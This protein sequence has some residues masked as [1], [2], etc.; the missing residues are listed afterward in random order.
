MNIKSTLWYV[1]A[2]TAAIAALCVEQ[3]ISD[4]Q[5][6]NTLY[7][8][9]LLMLYLTALLLFRLSAVFNEKLLAWL[10]RYSKL[11]TAA[12]LLLTLWEALSTKSDI[13]KLPFFP[14]PAQIV[15]TLVTERSTLFVSTLYSL[16]LFFAGLICGVALGITT[17]ILIGWS[18][19]WRYWL[20]PVI[21]IAGVI[22][23]VAWIPLALVVFPTSFV[24]GVFLLSIASW[25]SIAFMVSAGITS[26]P[27]AYYEVALT[28]GASRRWLL[29]N[30]ALPHAVPNIFTGIATSSGMCFTTLVITEMLGA[31]AG[32]GWYINWARAWAAY[33]KV[34][35]SICIM[36]VAFFA[37]LMVIN[38]F[39]SYFLR[40][41]KGIIK[42]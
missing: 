11:L 2:V 14:G 34:Y 39:R 40:W 19:Q 31:K 29:F 3:F 25:F 10:V 24:A 37:I 42:E 26:T 17:G 6:V 9:V 41:Q 5:N 15:Q 4:M 12:A 27:K 35:A 23:P 20:F 13:L 18:R 32:L 22:P 21:K 1:A 33:D 38:L 8:K 36:G 28:L 16:R 30:I 7:F